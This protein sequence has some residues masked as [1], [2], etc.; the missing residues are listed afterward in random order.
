ML[1]PHLKGAVLDVGCG[2]GKLLDYY[3]YLEPHY[4]G[5]DSNI[6]RLEEASLKHPR[7]TFKCVDIDERLPFPDCTFDTVILSAVLEHVLN[8]GQLLKDLSRVLKP[9][10]GIVGTSPTTFGND[11]VHRTLSQFSLLSREAAADHIAVFNRARLRNLAAAC[12]LELSLHRRFQVG[13]NQI[14]VLRPSGLG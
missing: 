4:V 7:A 10:G 9:S 14:F 5:I 13:C 12:D 3:D 2:P 11:I 6:S 8:L 1:A